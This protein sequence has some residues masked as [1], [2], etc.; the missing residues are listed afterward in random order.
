MHLQFLVE[1]Y[2]TKCLIDQLMIKL[3]PLNEEEILTYDVKSF[4]GIGTL[5]KTG[6]IIE[7]KTGKM[8]NDLPEYLR[9]FSKSLSGYGK[10]AAII[11][12]VDNDKRN[13]D[14]FRKELYKVLINSSVLIDCVLCIAIKEMEA[15]LLGDCEAIVSAYPDAKLKILNSYKQDAICDT[16]EVIAEA[17]YP[18]GLK[19]LMKKTG[20]AYFEIGRQKAEWA[21]CIG[22]YMNLEKN[23]S[24]SFNLFKDELD[25]RC[26]TARV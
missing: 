14:Q 18:G 19:T 21:S 13:P 15:W 5:G 16:W 1:D 24:P 26:I 6:S 7:R 17:V 20:G 4:R 10:N 23:N 2:S 22:K 9:G 25:K 8:L 3:V 12:I 11:V